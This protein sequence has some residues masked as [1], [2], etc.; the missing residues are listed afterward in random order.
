MTKFMAD[1]F[2]VLFGFISSVVLIVF[3]VVGFMIGNEESIGVALLGAIVGAIVS[4]VL[5]GFIAV[6]LNMEKMLEIIALNVGRDVYVDGTKVQSLRE[7]A[8]GQ[9][10]GMLLEMCKSSD[11]FSAE[12]NA[13]INQE[14][15][16]RGL[17]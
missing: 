11:G 5:C 10:D 17:K 9:S 2:Q 3:V 4:V 8:E 1:A 15:A 12:K 13:A 14:V 7:W 16:R 6:I